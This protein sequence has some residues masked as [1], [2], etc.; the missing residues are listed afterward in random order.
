MGGMGMG[1]KL[2]K[3][4]GDIFLILNFEWQIHC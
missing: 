3:T 4:E 2:E 1:W